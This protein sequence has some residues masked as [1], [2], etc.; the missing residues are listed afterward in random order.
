[1]I[2]I[3]TKFISCTNTKPSR[4]VATTCN[5][6]RH[7]VG[8]ASASSDPHKDAAEALIRKLG[9][10]GEWVGGG[11]KTGSAWVRADSCDRITVSEA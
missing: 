9:W 10:T 4:I 11:T 8:I 1:M 2:A 3:S 6:H 7:V 5:G